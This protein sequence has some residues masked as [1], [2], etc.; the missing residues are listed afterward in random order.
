MDYS[1]YHARID[2]K[3][4][5]VDIMKYVYED[6]QIH[7]Y[8]A[9]HYQPILKFYDSKEYEKFEVDRYES[10]YCD[11]H[12]WFVFTYDFDDANE[13]DTQSSYIVHAMRWDRL[14]D[15]FTDY[16]YDQG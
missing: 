15:E 1:D 6:M 4:L 3:S 9:S 2:F 13:S 10:N 5:F 8:E 16:D 14:L 7:K 12:I 11:N